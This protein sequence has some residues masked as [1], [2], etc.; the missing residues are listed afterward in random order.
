MDTIK[1]VCTAIVAAM[2]GAPALKKALESAKVDANEWN[3]ALQRATT[4]FA[5]EPGGMATTVDALRAVWLFIAW[6][7]P[8]EPTTRVD[9]K[10]GKAGPVLHGV[11]GAA[12]YTGEPDENGR[13][14]RSLVTILGWT[15]YKT[16]GQSH[17]VAKT[18]FAKN[19]KRNR[20]YGKP[21]VKNN[22]DAAL[23]CLAREGLIHR[24]GTSF[25]R[26]GAG[27]Q[28]SRAGEFVNGVGN[29]FGFAS[30]TGE[31]EVADDADELSAM[32]QAPATVAS[33]KGQATKARRAASAVKGAS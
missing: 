13:E 30:D 15:S 3:G 33:A 6:K 21:E 26:T 25:Y 32:M 19:G 24:L 27:P 11:P 5:S 31:L 18:E 8:A 20:S 22:L 12:L 10:T 29:V 7:Q 2:G 16:T 17:V 4:A 28:R 1:A 14:S 23:L 9:A